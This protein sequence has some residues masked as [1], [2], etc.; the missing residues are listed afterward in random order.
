MSKTISTIIDE[1]V[2]NQGGDVI[3]TKQLIHEIERNG[4]TIEYV[5]REIIKLAQGRIVIDKVIH[6]SKSALNNKVECL[7]LLTG[8]LDYENK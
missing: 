4:K 7:N 2:R 1:V 8:L 6:R 5:T 3:A